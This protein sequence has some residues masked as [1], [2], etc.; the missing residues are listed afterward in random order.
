VEWIELDLQTK[1]LSETAY[2]M[3]KLQHPPPNTQESTKRQYSIIGS[4]SL[5]VNESGTVAA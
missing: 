2:S 1:R 4:D 3:E 5:G